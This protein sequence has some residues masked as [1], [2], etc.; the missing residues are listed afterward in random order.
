MIL[1]V[2]ACDEGPDY[3]PAIRPQWL[4]TSEGSS[5]ADDQRATELKSGA[6]YCSGYCPYC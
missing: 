6:E 1:V 4:S 5:I 2:D 3:Y